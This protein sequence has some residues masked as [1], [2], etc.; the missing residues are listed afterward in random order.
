MMQRLFSL[1]AASALLLAPLGVRAADL[2]IWWDKPFYAQEDDALREVIAAF[3][4]KN[5]KQV[6]LVLHEL[7]EFEEKLPAAI[8]A[9]RPPD[10]AWGVAVDGHIP[11]WAANDRLVDLT[12][13]IGS[14]SNLF[15]PD[16]LAW[17]TLLDEKTGKRA[18]Y[19]RGRRR[20]RSLRYT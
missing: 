12:G 5:G 1:L 7:S 10:I 17:Y 19:A 13:T 20:Y 15:D 6:E 2:V 14:F 18:L 8:D 3:E 4:Q 11:E 9:G 16:A